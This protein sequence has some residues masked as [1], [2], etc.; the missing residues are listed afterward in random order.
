MLDHSRLMGSLSQCP[1]TFVFLHRSLPNSVCMETIRNRLLYIVKKTVLLF[2]QTSCHLSKGDTDC[3]NLTVIFQ[4]WSCSDARR[5]QKNLVAVLKELKLKSWEVKNHTQNA[6]QSHIYCFLKAIWIL[7]S[8][9]S[10]KSPTHDSPMLT[11]KML[12]PT[13]CPWQG[14]IQYITQAMVGPNKISTK[15]SCLEV[16]YQINKALLKKKKKT[17]KLVF[18]PVVPITQTFRRII[19]SRAKTTPQITLSSRQL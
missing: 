2:Q 17:S 3:I 6:F 5:D 8:G 10:L 14:Y 15:E 7:K 13:C 19:P 11:W 4:Y 18:W 16:C 9:C 12:P 1:V